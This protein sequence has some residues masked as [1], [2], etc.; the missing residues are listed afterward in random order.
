MDIQEKHVEYKQINSLA[1]AYM[2][3]AIYDVHI[4][5]HLLLSGKTKPNR[6]HREATRYVSAKAQANIL[7]QLVEENFL[8]EEELAIM[9]RGRNAKSGTI[10][11]NTD[12]Q[13]YRHSTAFEAVLGWIYL[14]ENVERLKELVE[15]SIK[16][17]EEKGVGTS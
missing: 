12:V 4:R 2:G 5:H 9:K 15:R 16:I 6:L 14:S 10:P 1:L 13:T 11:K 3:D 17:I 8:N 7:K